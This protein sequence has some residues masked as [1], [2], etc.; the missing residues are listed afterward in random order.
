MFT[1]CYSTILATAAFADARVKEDRRKEWDKLIEE[2][3]KPSKKSRDVQPGSETDD[4]EVQKPQEYTEEITEVPIST[5]NPVRDPT[6]NRFRDDSIDAWG[7]PLRTRLPSIGEKLSKLD[8]K[9]RNSTAERIALRDVDSLHEPGLD[10]VGQWIDELLDPDLEN[11]EPKTPLH[12][13]K[14][15]GMIQDLVNTILHQSKA[16]SKSARSGN[17]TSNTQQELSNMAKRFVALNAGESRIPSYNYDDIEFIDRERRR[18]HQS[19]WALSYATSRGQT[20]IDVT[21]TKMCYNMLVSTVP[22]TI[23]TYNILLNQFMNLGRPDLAQIV[24][25][26]FLYESR[27]KPNKKTI[28]LLLDHY[29]AKSDFPGFR[30][31]VQRMRVEKEDLRIRQRHTSELTNRNVEFWASNNKTTHRD[32]FIRQKMPRARPIYNSLIVGS[33]EFQHIRAAV[34]H[35]RSALR[36]GCEISA[37]TLCAVIKCVVDRLDAYAGASLLRALASQWEDGSIVSMTVFTKDL[38][39]RIFQLL[40]LCGIDADSVWSSKC[41]P[42]RVPP[43]ALSHILRRMKLDTFADAV[44]RSASFILK[45]DAALGMSG[46]DL[47][48][49]KLQPKTIAQ[50]SPTQRLDWA[51]QIAR[52]QNKVEEQRHARKLKS[53][54]DGRQLRLQ[55]LDNMVASGAVVVLTRQYELLEMQI[56]AKKLKLES[57]IR[58]IVPVDQETAEMYVRAL[59]TDASQQPLFDNHPMFQQGKPTSSNFDPLSYLESNLFD[60]DSKQFAWH[61]QRLFM[62]RTADDKV[63]FRKRTRPADSFAVRKRLT[64]KRVS[65]LKN[66]LIR[67]TEPELWQRLKAEQDDKKK[68]I[69]STSGNSLRRKHLAQLDGDMT[70]TLEKYIYN[71]F[72]RNSFLPMQEGQHSILS[73]TESSI[74]PDAA[75]SQ[76]VT[77]ITAPESRQISAP[78]NEVRRRTPE[79]P[80]L[81]LTF[82]PLQPLSKRYEA[83]A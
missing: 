13:F 54:H 31:I 38:R 24:V 74:V 26:S 8:W 64:L 76:Q 57:L 10:E 63:A 12:L 11:R 67:Y 21:I 29:R 80:P 45:L 82:P 77:P 18:L 43:A 17:S 59:T 48:H 81:S 25:D 42:S 1:A 55:V 44:E 22:P 71:T 50:E 3:K 72:G 40:L 61:Q 23:T 28:R 79:L 83:A 53:K 66:L 73:Q 46:L 35:V 14:Y 65:N 19:L 9:L 37:D 36:E 51:L 68:R 60:A 27:F 6:Y 62:L 4:W 2:V 69:K 30:D 78:K 33:L 34:R 7:L 15:E 39:Y 49:A 56:M 47:A 16:F 52:K 41:L 32:G 70:E 75:A 58:K 20:D 5:Y